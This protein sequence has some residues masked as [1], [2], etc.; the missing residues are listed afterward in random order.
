MWKTG[1][2]EF[3][4]VAALN[5]AGAATVGGLAM[6]GIARA[7]APRVVVIGGG[8]AGATAA[9]YLK[10][11][12]P[13]VEVTLIEANPQYHTCFM[14]NEVIGGERQIESL[15]IGYDGLRKHGV[16][17]V[18]DLVTGIDAVARTVTTKGGQSFGFDRCI[19]APGIELNYGG[20]EGYGPEAAERMPHAWKA[21]DQTT[22]LRRQLEAMPDGGTFVMVAPANPFRCPPGPYERASLIANYFKAHKPKSKVIILDAKDA[23]SKQPLFKEAW[24][25]FY[26]FGTADSMITWVPLK[27]GGKVTK[28]DPGSMTVTA[29]AGTFKGDVVNVIPP[30]GAGRIA[31]DAGLTEGPWVPVNKKTF[32]SKKLPGVYVMGDAADAATMP[33][34]AFGA[35]SQ[36]KVAAAAVISSLKGLEP[37]K[38]SYVNTCY[39]VAAT[40]HCFSIAG[41]YAH[42]EADNKLVELP[43]SGGISPL[44]ASPEDRR[45]ELAYAHSWFDN[46]RH[47]TWG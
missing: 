41:V 31:V 27:E 30:Q 35:N 29:E 26:G 12:D 21:G 32:E 36:A 47:D 45:R 9:K 42:S 24:E 22:L 1:R 16:T 14:S 4:K 40:D 37:P 6:P 46:I 11:F 44:G 43:D 38:P 8:P 2:R 25:K 3:L 34:S 17:V 15:R 7:A 39:S 18:H 23:F 28:V 13:A 33:K 19:A 10:R 5:L 20:I